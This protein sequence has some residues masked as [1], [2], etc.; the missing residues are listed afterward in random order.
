MAKKPSILYLNLKMLKISKSAWQMGL[1]LIFIC[2][3]Q[4]VKFYILSEISKAHKKEHGLIDKGLETRLK[5]VRLPN[6]C[7]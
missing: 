7:I 2:G 3:G 4:R 5:V 6:L 1:D